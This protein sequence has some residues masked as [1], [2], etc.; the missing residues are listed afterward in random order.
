MYELVICKSVNS[1]KQKAEKIDDIV[2]DKRQSVLTLKLK[3]NLN[4]WRYRVLACERLVRWTG[5]T[6]SSDFVRL[7]TND[8]R[9]K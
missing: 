1:T 7:F 3:K 4:K 2:R 8:Y 5:D 9:E 6:R